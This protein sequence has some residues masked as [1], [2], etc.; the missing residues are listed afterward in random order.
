MISIQD[1]PD[2]NDY[3]QIIL[4][5]ANFNGYDHYGSFEACADAA[6]LKKRETLIDLQTELFFA[7]RAGT[8]LGQTSNLLNSYK[9]LEPYFRK[10]LT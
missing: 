8:H 7:W 6:N 3:E 9:E 2:K 4:F 1:L 10:L 5:A